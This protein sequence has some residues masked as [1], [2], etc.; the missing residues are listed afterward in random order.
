MIQ[1]PLADLRNLAE[2]LALPYFDLL[3]CLG[4]YSIHPGGLKKTRDLVSHMDLS[5]SQ[6]ILEIGSGNGFTSVALVKSGA[7][8]TIVDPTERLLAAALR[9][10]K[11]HTGKTPQYYCCKAEDMPE[12]IQYNAIILEA[13]YGFIADKAAFHAKITRLLET[14][15]KIGIIDFHYIKQPPISVVERMQKIF[16]KNFIVLDES[17]WRKNFEEFELTH[18]ENFPAQDSKRLTAGILME[19]LES[20]HLITHPIFQEGGAI[21]KVVDSINSYND[22]FNENKTYMSCFSAVWKK[23]LEYHGEAN[24]WYQH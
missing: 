24:D 16:G 13:V 19:S 9:N 1:N 8:L 11:L 15:G 4:F 22:L 7:R 20:N 3:G 2:L 5:S 6:K 14:T 23:R 21:Q 18:W 12:T 17:S 10:C